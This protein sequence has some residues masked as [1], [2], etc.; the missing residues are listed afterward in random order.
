MSKY[1]KEVSSGGV[2]YRKKDANI[3]IVLIKR[4]TKSK[5]YVWCLPKGKI[6]ESESSPDAAIR[7]V[8]E[9]TGFLGEIVSGIGTVNYW[10]HSPEDKMKVYKTVY[11]FLMRYISGVSKD[12]DY[13]V[14]EVKWFDFSDALNVSSYDSEREI[15]KKAKE[16]IES[17]ARGNS[18]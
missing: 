1:R 14:E 10:F 12:H 3:E 18:I 17:A 5:Q 13:E 16:G 9:E 11:F 6:E 2:L 7:E 15:I 4:V 8:K